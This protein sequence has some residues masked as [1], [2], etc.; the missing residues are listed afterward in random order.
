MKKRKN[1]VAQTR[2]ATG[3]KLNSSRKLLCFQYSFEIVPSTQKRQSGLHKNREES[4]IRRLHLSPKKPEPNPARTG[5]LS[6]TPASIWYRAPFGILPPTPVQQGI[7]L[8]DYSVRQYK[9]QITHPYNKNSFL[10]L[11]LPSVVFTDILFFRN[12]AISLFYRLDKRPLFPA[13]ISPQTLKFLSK[14]ATL[15]RLLKGNRARTGPLSFTPASIWYRAPFGILPPTPVQ[16]GIY[17]T[18]YSVRQYKKQITHPYNSNSTPPSTYISHPRN[19]IPPHKVTTT[20]QPAN[21]T[22]HHLTHFPTN[23][24]PN[25][26]HLTCPTQLV[27][28]TSHSPVLPQYI[29]SHTVTTDRHLRYQRIT[30]FHQCD[31]TWIY[32]IDDSGSNRNLTFPPK[33]YS[34]KKRKNFVAQTHFATRRKLNSSRKLLCF[35]YS[36]E[37]VPSTQ[38]R[39]SGHPSQLTAVRFRAYPH[40]DYFQEES[41]IRRLHLSPKKP[42]PNP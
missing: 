34:M 31:T 42:E 18:D 21:L 28:F 2:F 35:Q 9:K 39:Q 8:T 29:T 41:K 25:S 27:T 23:H 40:K 4:K 33:K 38:K 12:M 26:N 37:I 16:Q 13:P 36:F 6:F 15:K 3:R 1:F 32:K 7:Y 20:I 10:L 19:N 14:N 30:Q 11:Q 17:L 22:T 5:P 24:P